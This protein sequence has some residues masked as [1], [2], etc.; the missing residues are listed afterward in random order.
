MSPNRFTDPVALRNCEREPIH[1]PGAIQ[2]HGVLLTL[3]EPELTVMQV[4]DN[5]EQHLGRRADELLD[6]PVSQLLDPDTVERIREALTLGRWD[7]LN[8][9]P[10]NAAGREFDGIVHQ[11]A[12]VV[13]LELEPVPTPRPPLSLHHPLRQAL[14]AVQRAQTMEELFD[15]LVSQVRRLTGL[16]R[17]MLYRFDELGHGSVD[18]ETK[19][20]G[21]DPYLGLHYPASD[22]P[23]QARELYLQ[24][25]LRIIPDARYSP[26]RLVPERRPDTGEPLDLSFAVLRSVSPVHLEYMANMGVRMSMSA[27]LVV[28]NRLWGLVSCINHSEPRL[29]P[30]EVRSAVEVLARIASLQI[31]AVDEREAATQRALRRPAQNVL[32]DAMRE[33]AP[34][35]DVLVSLLDRPHEL[36]SLV[37]ADSVAVVGAG[38]MRTAGNAPPAGVIEKV[39]RWLE[40]RGEQEPFAT[41]ALPAQMKAVHVSTDTASGL[42]TFALPGTPRRRLLWFRHEFARTV[43]WGGDPRKAVRPG[44]EQRLHPRRSFRKWQEEVRRQSRPWSPSDLDAAQELRRNTVEIDLGRQVQREQQ[45]VRARNELVAVVSHDLRSPLTVIHIQAG[46]LLRHATGDS[47]ASV[48]VRTAAERVQTAVNR[49][50]ALIRNLLDLTRI[51]AGRFEVR[52]QPEPVRELI[53]E[54]L[55]IA[56]PLAE[57]KQLSL[58]DEVQEDR[59]VLVDRERVFQ[60]LSNLLGNAIKF[61]PSGGRILL[62]VQPRRDDVE[63]TVA[64]NGPG[65]SPEQL[66][67]VFDRYWQARETSHRGT[68]LGLFIARGIVEAHGGEISAESVPGAGATFRFTLPAA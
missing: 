39:A 66:P 33:S 67:R 30:Y 53:E 58:I 49:M 27:S 68:G 11:H 54:A 1:I 25:W 48:R 56:R 38:E 20:D 44:D 15:T 52:P 34:T 59:L 8:P 31:A 45:A 13:L 10:I 12:G 47:P 29:V 7:D 40:A 63:F 57:A 50:D 4:S 22:I 2:P 16:E 32:A 35:T 65:L 17:V 9:V 36:L 55:V 24:N 51:E 46:R 42:L 61:T 23:R 26:A 3:A 62:R 43:N 64:D 37:D 18:A 60:V 41:S 5:V 19:A 21:L 6:Q 14:Q 28:R